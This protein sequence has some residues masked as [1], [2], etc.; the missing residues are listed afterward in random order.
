MHSRVEVLRALV[1]QH[2]PDSPG[3][4]GSLSEAPSSCFV[5]GAWVQLSVYM[6]VCA[7]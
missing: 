4:F 1:T 3:P 6:L 7:L 2:P 5:S